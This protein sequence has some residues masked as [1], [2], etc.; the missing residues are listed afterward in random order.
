MDKI[1]H[2]NLLKEDVVYYIGI[3][4][5]EKAVKI[6]HELAD[7]YKEAQYQC[8][9]GGYYKNKD[10]DKSLK[11]FELSAKQGNLKAIDELVVYYF[12]NKD[13]GSLMDLINCVNKSEEDYIYFIKIAIAYIHA[14]DKEVDDVVKTCIDSKSS[15]TLRVLK[16]AFAYYENKE[17]FKKA[18]KVLKE[19][20]SLHYNNAY[21]KIACYYKEGKGVEKD[22]NKY[23]EYLLYA[24]NLYSN[25]EL[26][27]IYYNGD[28]VD[29]N[30]DKALFYFFTAYKK[31]HKMAP[32]Y[33][34][35]IYGNKSLHLYDFKRSVD[36]MEAFFKVNSNNEKAKEKIRNLASNAD[37]E[38]KEKIKTMM[39]KYWQI[40]DFEA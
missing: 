31:G 25:Y 3:N 8:F 17:N 35:D 4:D 2:L 29:I 14:V 15:Q 38:L 6:A 33:M 32:L 40:E 30:Y 36:W 34:S 26:G 12:K 10:L 5:E 20:E 27:L 9:L 28:G 39:K 37:D 13:T 23:F 19:I 24:N 16:F 7:D 22:L 21:Y 18:F 11:Y 1:D